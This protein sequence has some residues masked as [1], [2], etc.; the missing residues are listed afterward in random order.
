MLVLKVPQASRVVLEPLEP[1]W[2]DFSHFLVNFNGFVVPGLLVD[3]F[4]HLTE[5]PACFSLFVRQ[6]RT[7]D[8]LGLFA[9]ELALQLVGSAH[10]AQQVH[11]SVPLGIHL[12]GSSDSIFA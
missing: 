6:L 7:V 12:V 9:V 2:L 1:I 3:T 10:D 8:R 4:C 11:Q 5:Y